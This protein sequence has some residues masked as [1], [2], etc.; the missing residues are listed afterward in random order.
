MNKQQSG[1]TLIEMVIVIILLGIL[2]AVA[3]PQLTNVTGEARIGVQNGT[4][5]ALKSS[6]AIAYAIKR[7]VPTHAEVAAQMLDPACN[8]TAGTGI[9]CPGVRNTADTGDAIFGV[10][11]NSASGTLINTPANIAIF[12]N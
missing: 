4:L 11:N 2:A 5:G 12:Q 3:V 8:T 9:V 1:F 6:W 10:A 7:G